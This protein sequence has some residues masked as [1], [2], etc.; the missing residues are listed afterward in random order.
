MNKGE[1]EGETPSPPDIGKK[2]G[3]M[4]EQPA[5]PPNGDEDAKGTKKAVE[6]DVPSPRP[7][8]EPGEDVSDPIKDQPKAGEDPP[9]DKDLPEKGE[10]DKLP[11]QIRLVHGQ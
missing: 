10:T 5:A 6:S 1:K 11:Q 2:K 3:P 7:G 8:D 4:E 9:V